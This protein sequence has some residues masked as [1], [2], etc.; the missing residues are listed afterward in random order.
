M[1]SRGD[2]LAMCRDVLSAMPTHIIIA[3][4]I[5]PSTLKR[6]NRLIRSFLWHGRK[7]VSNSHFMVSWRRVCMHVSLGG[8]GIPDLHR[9]DIP[10]RARWMWLQRTD[11]SHPWQHLHIPRWPEVQAIFKAS[12]TWMKE[13]CPRGNNKVN[14]Y[15]LI[16]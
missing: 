2:R 14:I 1:M 11:A 9:A 16:S 7:D 15:F 12:T 13:I 4:A 8:L 10:L 3:M 6:I 5:K